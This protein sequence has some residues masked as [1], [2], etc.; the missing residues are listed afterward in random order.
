MQEI[1]VPRAQLE[2]IT[3]RKYKKWWPGEVGRIKIE[4]GSKHA[5]FEAPG[6]GIQPGLRVGSIREAPPP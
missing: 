1:I 4:L 2:K 6:E 3:V 5:S